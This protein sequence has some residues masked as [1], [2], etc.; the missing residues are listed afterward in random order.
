MILGSPWWAALVIPIAAT[1]WWVYRT[2]DTTHERILGSIML[3]ER[4]Q[5]ISRSVKWRPPWRALIEALLLMGLVIAL[6]DIRLPGSRIVEIIAIDN[7]IRMTAVSDGAP[8]GGQS[9]FVLAKARAQ[10]ALDKIAS[11]AR[12]A[13][14]TLSA[15]T[16]PL[17]I[18][19]ARAQIEAL[20]ISY[21]PG[22]IVE[23][24]A[25]ARAATHA[26]RVTVIAEGSFALPKPEWLSFISVSDRALNNVAL[27]DF[28]PHS[29]VL[30]ITSYSEQDAPFVV[31]VQDESGAVIGSRKGT[32]PPHSAR[33]ISLA[34]I[35]GFPSLG[36]V[37]L[38]TSPDAL[39]VDNTYYFSTAS[40][41]GVIAVDSPVELSELGITRLASF[42][43]AAGDRNSSLKSAA[44][45]IH[46]RNLTQVESASGCNGRRLVIMPQP[47]TSTSRTESVTWWLEADELLRYANLALLSVPF[48][49]PLST[50]HAT[51]LVLSRSGAL[52]TR[53]HTG[54]CDTVT[55]GFELLPFVPEGN[56]TVNILTLNL[57]K[58]LSLG[59]ERDHPLD[60][61]AP[62]TTMT[63]L[64]PLPRKD[65][66][67]GDSVGGPGLYKVSS[68]VSG[69]I[70]D[71]IKVKSL[72][73]T[74]VSDLRLSVVHRAPNLQQE[75]SRGNEAVL[76]PN[77]S[78]LRAALFGVALLLLVDLLWMLRKGAGRAR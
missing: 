62:G 73:S 21:Q 29:K 66:Q 19:E 59:S 12:V 9:R 42:H 75:V 51:P 26:D 3:L 78:M 52:M 77:G 67:S 6:V 58:W 57:L 39:S 31:S 61:V 22:S 70:V 69:V 8:E 4:A 28:D 34:D 76:D 40:N 25:R 46:R 41:D 18:G 16:E 33:K 7:G 60:R 55:V 65:F 23:L 5:L 44:T 1:I 47:L 36:S 63:R 13:V 14:V 10:A 30:S 71:A 74:A 54:S 50:E 64:L 17:P 45:L 49:A 35:E 2:G 48:V 68:T 38:Q 43:F 24:A 15:Q 53:S 37:T 11:S 72:V 32:V 20:E 27:S 56:R